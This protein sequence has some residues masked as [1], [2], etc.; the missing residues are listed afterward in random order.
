MPYRHDLDRAARLHE[1]L[2][3]ELDTV[4][5][6]AR[7]LR[8]ELEQPPSSSARQVD[9]SITRLRWRLAAGVA[10][11]ATLSL[12]AVTALRTLAM[13]S[14]AE[15]GIWAA[16]LPAAGPVRHA[17]VQTTPHRPVDPDAVER[18]FGGEA[19]ARC[20]HP[21]GPPASDE[22]W[23]H[24]YIRVLEHDER[25]VDARFFQAWMDRQTSSSRKLRITPVKEQ[26]HVVGLRVSVRPDDGFSAL[27]FEDGDVVDS[28]NGFGLTDPDQALEAYGKL[29][30]AP[31][32][33][34][35]L[36]RKGKP[37]TLTFRIARS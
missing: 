26:Q 16:A 9:P 25:W 31:V 12:V 29:S 23:W 36:R 34:V 4:E 27:G 37:M 3:H 33:R 10:G 24:G 6:R 11:A 2:L 22:P 1:E 35:R 7:K 21:S 28:I 20:T 5:E 17:A 14:L 32:L 18:V 8:R 19:I 30:D 13:A 15:V